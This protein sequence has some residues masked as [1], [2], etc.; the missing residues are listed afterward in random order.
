MGSLVMLRLRQRLPELMDDPKLDAKL[1]VQALRGLERINRWSR[2]AGLLWPLVAGLARQ[3]A[4]RP[5]RVLDVATGGGDVPCALWHLADRHGLRL[6]LTACDL[7]ERALDFARRQAERRQVP[8]A[9]VCCNVLSEPLPSGQDVVISSLFLHH[10]D[11]GETVRTLRHMAAAAERAVIISDLARGAA[12][13]AL[14]F[15]G[16]RLLTRSPV[17]HVDGPLSVRAAYTPREI[18][19]LAEQAG[20]PGVAVQRRWPSRLLLTWY[21]PGCLPQR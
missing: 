11:E 10:L 14:A 3:V 15:L 1:H 7:S 20:L 2:S 17:V 16:T 8:I 21:Q 13:F 9:F 6:E 18:R 19:A 4:P 12:G 5:L